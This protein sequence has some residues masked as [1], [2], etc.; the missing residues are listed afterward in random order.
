MHS[1]LALF[2]LALLKCAFLTGFAPG[3]IVVSILGGFYGRQKARRKAEVIRIDQYAD[4]RSVFSRRRRAGR[5][6]RE[7]RA[8]AR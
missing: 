5:S 7:I 4:Q 3:L 1:D 8:L 2:A 6:S